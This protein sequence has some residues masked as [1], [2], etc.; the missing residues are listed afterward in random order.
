LLSPPVAQAATQKLRLDSERF[1]DRL[2]RERTLS[3][4]ADQPL[5]GFVEQTL[6]RPPLASALFWKHRRASS[7]IAIISF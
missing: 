7:R 6:A 1:A 3:A 4:F 2:K 5:L